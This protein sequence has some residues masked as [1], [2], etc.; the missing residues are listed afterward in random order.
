MYAPSDI[1]QQLLGWYDT[2]RRTLP[3]RALPGVTPDPYHVWLSEIMLQQTTVATVKGYFEKF[4]ARWPRVHDMAA[5][6]QD[7][8]MTM[9]AGLGY[10]AR[11]RNMHK[12]AITVTHEHN[13]TFPR[14]SAELIKLPGIGPYSAAAIAA[15]AF[16]ESAAV[17]DGNVERIMARLLDDH[18]P[19]PKLKDSLRAALPE[20]IPSDRPGDFA[21]ASMDLGATICTPKKP[22]CLI[23]PWRTV[24]KARAVGSM[25]LLPIKA[26]KKLKPTRHANAFWLVADGSVLL[27]RRPEKG[28]LGATVGLPVGA[29]LE[30]NDFPSNN[31]TGAPVATKWATLGEIATHT[32][33]HFHLKSRIMFAELN[34]RPPLHDN[35]Q[36]FWCPLDQLPDQ[37]LPTVFKKMAKLVLHT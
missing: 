1:A 17:V 8:V 9:W 23:C 5:A 11:A 28:L 22:N 21:Q 15:I 16:N 2:H 29:W 14:T 25:E 34:K 32:F 4:L 20:F 26:P 37:G 6:S 27:E 35:R 36:L 13:G 3:W 30:N 7:E 19:L 24:C 31:T 12:C 10:Y 33:T 18:T